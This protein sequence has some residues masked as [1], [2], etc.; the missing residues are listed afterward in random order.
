MISAREAKAL[1]H[2]FSIGTQRQPPVIPEPLRAAA[3]AGMDLEALQLAALALVAQHARLTR[4]P[5]RVDRPDATAALD[6][7]CFVPEHLRAPIREFLGRLNQ[8]DALGEPTVGLVL[9]TLKAMGLRLH[10]FDIA[11]VESVVKALPHLVDPA[12]LAVVGLDPQPPVDE[13]NWCAVAATARQTFFRTLRLRD[14][15]AARA[16]VERDLPQAPAKVRGAVLQRLQDRLSPAD[17]PLLERFTRDRSKAARETAHTLLGQLPGTEEYRERLGT[18]AGLFRPSSLGTSVQPLACRADGHCLAGTFGLRYSH[19][20]AALDAGLPQPLTRT[21]GVPKC[22]S[23]AALALL[24]A[25]LHEGDTAVAIELAGR[26][27]LS[28]VPVSAVFE[29]FGLTIAP[30]T[31][32]SV[33]RE[34]PVGPLGDHISAGDPHR[35]LVDLYGGP[36]PEALGQQLAE[37]ALYQ[38]TGHRIH[39]VLPLLLP[40]PARKTG[41]AAM[42][43]RGLHA[44]SAPNRCIAILDGLDAWAAAGAKRQHGSR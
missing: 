4:A 43:Q 3:P 25:A 13:T 12:D 34:M 20:L 19:L 24:F 31:V 16:L 36:L 33:L 15:D 23:E 7:D 5:L 26:H 1:V 6:P 21:T 40:A 9:Q 39:A 28:W 14:P 29:R 18:A 37:T 30:D 44:D 38:P 42:G 41:L 22:T 11:H 10:P 2:A 32:T 35:I 17:R 27:R 8:V